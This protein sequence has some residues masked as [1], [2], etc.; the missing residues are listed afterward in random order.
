MLNSGTVFLGESSIYESAH[1]VALELYEFVSKIQKPKPNDPTWMKTTHSRCAEL[2]VRV[3]TV[4]KNMSDRQKALTLALEN[5]F[6]SL[7]SYLHEL[8]GSP[9]SVRLRQSFRDL[10]IAY[11]DLVVQCRKMKKKAA[12]P[13]HRADHFSHLKPSNYA[14]NF[15][16]IMMGLT[17][18]LLYE[19]VLNQSQALAILLFF[20]TLA[21]AME[22][23]RRFSPAINRFLMD[24]VFK[25]ISRPREENH[26][27]SATFYVCGLVVITFMFPKAATLIGVLILTFADP[28][29][30]LVGKRWGRKKL[31]REKSYVGT[32]GFLITASTATFTYLAFSLPSL[33]LSSKLLISGSVALVGTIAELFSEYLDDNFT[34]PVLCAGVAAFFL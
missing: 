8:E 34:I 9:N 15:F 18:G 6:N 2:Q 33:P 12:H 14:R 23:S 3:A 17:S 28:A 7:Q 25:L 16:H 27:N 31:W 20:S 22:T 4:R 13:S 30:A 11:E 21:I 32:L 19:F 1:S 5:I 26:I 24:R 10:S 29:A